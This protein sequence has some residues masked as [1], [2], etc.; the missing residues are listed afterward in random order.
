MAATAEKK[1]RVNS[2]ID[3]FLACQLNY[4]L[5]CAA[6]CCALHIC[7]KLLS[8]YFYVTTAQNDIGLCHTI[9][10][11][12]N[13]RFMHSSVRLSHNLIYTSRMFLIDISVV[14]AMNSLPYPYPMQRL[15]VNEAITEY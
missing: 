8:G 9:H 12:I 7:V 14:V 6:R 5:K 4:I 13:H 2:Q 15:V 1:Q 3:Q 10:L 11:N